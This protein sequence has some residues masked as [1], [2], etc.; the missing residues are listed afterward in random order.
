[1]STIELK[2]AILKRLE[3]VNDSTLRDMLALMEFE[4]SD[5]VYKLSEEEKIAI[6]AGL[7]DIKNGRTHTHAKVKEEVEK[8][9]KK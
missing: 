1:M 7:D 8:W 9:L 3:S 2:E 6:E 5:E 4:S